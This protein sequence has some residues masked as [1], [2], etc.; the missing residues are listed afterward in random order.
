MATIDEAWELAEEEGVAFI[1]ATLN[2]SDDDDNTIEVGDNILKLDQLN[3]ILFNISGGTYQYQQ[4]QA[5]GGCWHAD[6]NIDG[7]FESRGKARRCATK[8]MTDVP[9]TG[10]THL[11]KMFMVTFPTIETIEI[12]KINTTSII[13]GWRLRMLFGAVFK[14]EV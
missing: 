2:D 10:G 7:L 6:G 13:W 1:K 3:T 9:Y 5:G 8:I 14:S 4:M 12:Q 11:V